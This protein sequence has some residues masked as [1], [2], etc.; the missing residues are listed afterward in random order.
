[1]DQ[2]WLDVL[3]LPTTKIVGVPLRNV[4]RLQAGF[5]PCKTSSQRISAFLYSHLVS[6]ALGVK[7]RVLESLALSSK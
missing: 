6:F 5:T 2:G 3:H 1:M 7:T 4:R